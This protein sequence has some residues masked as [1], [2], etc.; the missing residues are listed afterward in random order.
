M[1]KTSTALRRFGVGVL[2]AATI[3]SGLVAFAGSASAATAD[4]TGLSIAPTAAATSTGENT[5]QLYTVSATEANSATGGEITVTLQPTGGVDSRFCSGTPHAYQTTTPSGAAVATP[6]NPNPTNGGADSA[7]FTLGGNNKVTVGVNEAAAAAGQIQITASPYNGTSATPASGAPTASALQTIQTAN[8]QNDIVTALAAT[9]SSQSG[10]QGSSVNYTVTATNGSSNVVQGA[11]IYYSVK[12]SQGNST[13]Q[14]NVACNNPTDQ[15]GQVTCNV[16]VPPTTGVQSGPY[17][18]T[19]KAPQNTAL[20]NNPSSAIPAGNSGPTTTA[21]LTSSSPAPTGS[22]VTV[23]CGTAKSSRT[24]S[25]VC[26]D[27]TTTKTET[28][29]ATV[30]SNPTTTGGTRPAVAGTIVSFNVSGPNG[31]W[32]GWTGCSAPGTETG[33]VSPLQCTTGADGTCSTTFTVTGTP[34]D[35]DWFRVNATIQTGTPA[36]Q[37]TVSSNGGNTHDAFVVF[38]NRTPPNTAN[39]ISVS[40][41]SAT[42]TV[43]Q[44]DVVTAKVTDEQGNAAND[45]Q[46]VTFTITGVGTFQGGATQ[47]T[48]NANA[49]GIAQVTVVSGR[50]GTSHVTASLNPTFSNCQQPAN[51]NTGGKAGNC[52]ATTDITW[53]GGSTSGQRFGVSVKLACFSHHKHKVTC[54]AQLNKTISGVT[55]VFWTKSGTKVGSDVTG[56]AGKAKIHLSGL[57]SGSKH[58]YQAHAKRSAHTRSAW[59]KLATVFV[60]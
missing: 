44:Q 48:V 19:F 9:P 38:T 39:N 13:G 53:S 35:G 1:S 21:T 14:D 26:I 15:N 20:Q 11:Y 52:S 51:P 36:A 23:D 41:A 58:R 17:T 33:A 10:T 54:V 37:T 49:Q 5:C 32:A 31:C 24:A 16:N 59:S 57:K 18:I 45:Q 25:N 50:A 60:K 22:T 8:A 6:Y 3:S 46:P 42:A 4:I 55:V 43:G 34:N 30:T 28:F 7:T 2:S 47:T 40:A 56:S 29:T 12:S 27:S